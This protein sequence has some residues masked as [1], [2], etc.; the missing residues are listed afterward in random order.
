MIGYNLDFDIKF[1]NAAL[2]RIDLPKLQNKTYDIMKYV[3]RE[4]LFLQ[5]YKLQTVLKEYGIDEK[6]PHRA[7]EDARLSLKLISKVNNLR[8]KLNYK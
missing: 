6:V 4:K 8:D 2:K 3:K 1:I 7:L 5:N